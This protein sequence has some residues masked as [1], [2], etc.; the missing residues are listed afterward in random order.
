MSTHFTFVTEP[1]SKSDEVKIRQIRECFT[2]E[3]I[4]NPHHFRYIQ[5]D[6]WI[7]GKIFFTGMIKGAPPEDPYFGDIIPHYLDIRISWISDENDHGNIT[8]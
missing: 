8:V 2:A 6:T 5:V 1:L 7:S 4:K 3:H